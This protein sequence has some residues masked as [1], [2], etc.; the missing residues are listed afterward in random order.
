MRRLLVEC[1]GPAPPRAVEQQR[2]EKGHVGTGGAAHEPNDAAR[3][4]Q[5]VQRVERLVGVG[6]GVG[7]GAGPGLGEGQD[8]G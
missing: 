8:P 7:A 2:P 6:V 3:L 5:G 4:G 1:P